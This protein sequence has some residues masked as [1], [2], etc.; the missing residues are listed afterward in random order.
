MAYLR[1][2]ELPA[3][4]CDTHN[5]LDLADQH[6]MSVLK[7]IEFGWL[8]DCP[9]KGPGRKLENT[10]VEAE[11]SSGAYMSSKPFSIQPFVEGMSKYDE[12]QH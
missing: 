11:T 12:H 2:D 3:L 10:T 8:R 7:D 1:A 5:R 6:W 9:T 4:T